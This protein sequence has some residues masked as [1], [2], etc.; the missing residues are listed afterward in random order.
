MLQAFLRLYKYTLHLLFSLL[1]DWTSLKNGVLRDLLHY[2]QDTD[3]SDVNT[4][5]KREVWEV[6]ENRC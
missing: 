4:Q 5:Q 6:G 3:D 1:L 2:F